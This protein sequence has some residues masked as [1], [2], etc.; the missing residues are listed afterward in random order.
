MKVAAPAR[1]RRAPV[2]TIAQV[3]SQARLVSSLWWLA[4]AV[5]FVL[6]AYSRPGP[7]PG[8]SGDGCWSDRGV[9]LLIGFVLGLPVTL[10][11]MTVCAI[12]IGFR[13]RS[14]RSG[15]LLGTWVAWLGLGLVAA[16]AL[17]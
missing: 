4:A 5:G 6:Y 10:I 1:H 13:A 12:V 16:Y 14:A 8:C 7:A 9:L 17:H 15:V 3:R 11:G 2:R